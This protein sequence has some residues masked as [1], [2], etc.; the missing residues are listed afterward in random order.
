VGVRG[1]SY[2]VLAKSSMP[3]AQILRATMHNE[4]KEHEL[5]APE[6]P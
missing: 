2:C 5:M 1:T 6:N 4:V 3:G